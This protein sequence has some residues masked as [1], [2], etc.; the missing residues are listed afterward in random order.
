MRSIGYRV[1][2]V[3][4]AH[5]AGL[6][7][8]PAMHVSSRASLE[9]KLHED[10]PRDPS[11]F[12]GVLDLVMT[13]VLSS[14]GHL[15]H[16]RFFGFIP[17]PSNWV[18]AMADAVVAGVTPFC[19]TWL[20]GS[21][22]TQI[23]LVTLGWLKQLLGYPESAA[24]LF[25]S[26]GS[27][28][29]LTALAAARDA[30][31]AVDTSEH[32]VY[33]TDQTHSS[34]GRA[35]KI[36][37]YRESQIRRLGTD[38]SLRLNVDHLQDAINADR[39]SG[40]KPHLVVANAGTTNTGAID[41]LTDIAQICR[42]Q[43]MWMHVDGAYGAAAAI[44]DRGA[45]LLDGIGHADSI[46]L[47]PHKWLFQPYAMGCLLVRN[48]G[49]LRG[50]FHAM[51]EYMQ[52]T[53]AE[54]ERGEPNLCEYGPELTR[55]FRALKLWMSLK[56]FGADAFGRAVEHGISM[57]ES[58]QQILAADACWELISPAQ[59]GIVCFRY[60]APGMSDKQLDE[61]N[62]EIARSAAEDGCCFL[63]TTQV[64]GRTVLRMCTIQPST[65][66]AD[67]RMSIDC[68]RRFGEQLAQASCLEG[69]VQ[70]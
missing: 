1:V 50:F 11:D 62:S 31:P 40:L 44:C 68:L 35:L 29:N 45:K 12:N 58:V 16:P 69:D 30:Q 64:R 8:K 3:L 24:G 9:S 55:P 6:H 17:T 53:E 20:E 66:E 5:W 60:A 15:N 25:V 39:A 56:V 59:L 28:A 47:D 57:A 42:E 14:I 21:G 41:P 36:L 61:L 18:S 4:V 10:L 13:D 2:D 32:A 70:S 27:I 19:G 22:P 33:Y 46:T 67:L 26:G 65:T 38:E 51:P 49:T 7:D 43:K 37:G 23:E 54:T 52:D 63:S 48:A 34:I